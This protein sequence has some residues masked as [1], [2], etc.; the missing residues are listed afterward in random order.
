MAGSARGWPDLAVGDAGRR[1]GG[2]GS[3]REVQR[4]EGKEI[5]GL[6]RLRSSRHCWGYDGDAGS[7]LGSPEM[8][9][10]ERGEGRE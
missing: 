3:C 5:S 9:E 8:R 10:R 4:E 1:R 2:R 7:Q 6:G